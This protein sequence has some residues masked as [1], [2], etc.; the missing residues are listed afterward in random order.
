MG[1]ESIKSSRKKSVITRIDDNYDFSKQESKITKTGKQQSY[2]ERIV[3]RD[4]SNSM[5]KIPKLHNLGNLSQFSTYKS[6]LDIQRINCKK[7]RQHSVN[8]SQFEMTSNH[9]ND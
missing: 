2:N 6:S 4:S 5:I 3:K 8:S 9:Y 1:G 7:A